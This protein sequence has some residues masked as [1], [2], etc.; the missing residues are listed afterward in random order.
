[1]HIEEITKRTLPYQIAVATAAC[2]VV[3]IAGPRLFGVSASFAPMFEPAAAAEI[4]PG[5]FAPQR[6]A[7]HVA[8]G[9]DGTPDAGVA[10]DAVV[11]QLNTLP[12]MRALRSGEN[13]NASDCSDKAYTAFARISSTRFT[14]IEGIDT[15]VGLELS[16]CAGWIVDEWHNH[17]VFAQ[18]PSPDDLR[19]LGAATVVRM[20]LWMD[21]H[22]VLA[23]NLLGKGLA[24]DPARMQPSFFYSLYKTVD[25]NMRAYVRPGGP[26]YAAGMRSGD[27]V[28]KLDGKFW[29][30]YGTYQTQRRA[31][32]GKPHNFD[33]T[34]NAQS[35][36]VQ[37]GEPFE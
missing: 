29:W 22:P 6:A 3:V 34:R 7:M 28:D 30:E 12:N 4:L 37:L 9:T 2:I 33:V 23:G 26:A 36:H 31:Y 14:I 16:D 24:Y 27:V 8:V 35:Y 13:P 20:K 1:M 10:A 17:Q 21:D 5:L 18:G 15:D 11:A 25:G 32:D 19:S